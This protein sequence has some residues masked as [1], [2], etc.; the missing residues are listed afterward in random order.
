MQRTLRGCSSKPCDLALVARV[1]AEL[2]QHDFVLA[3][4]AAARGVVAVTAL[5]H[6]QPGAQELTCPTFN[7]AVAA[8]RMDMFRGTIAAAVCQYAEVVSEALHERLPSDQGAPLAC[9][10]SHKR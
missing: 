8:S 6:S 9:C 5:L 1:T 2:T 3:V 4:A 7:A 10:G